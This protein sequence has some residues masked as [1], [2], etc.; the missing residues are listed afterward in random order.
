MEHFPSLNSL[1]SDS[2]IQ[3]ALW[4]AAGVLC[5]SFLVTTLL[6]IYDH[7]VARRQNNLLTTARKTD[8]IISSLFPKNIQE[9]YGLRTILFVPCLCYG[10]VY[11]QV[12]SA[13]AIEID[14]LIPMLSECANR[15][16]SSSGLDA[17]RLAGWKE[18]TG[19]IAHDA[20]QNSC[21][22]ASPIAD[23][24]PETTVMFADVRVC[25]TLVP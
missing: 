6:A 13:N 16:L 10:F 23:L 17:G 22:T 14:S 2:D 25:D 18:Y 24:F 19:K 4:Y 21:S 11:E 3:D 8:A 20:S 15:M 5:V 7:L 12:F 1:K 9:R